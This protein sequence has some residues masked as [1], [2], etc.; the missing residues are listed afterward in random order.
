MLLK[1]QPMLTECCHCRREMNKIRHATFLRAMNIS[2][3]II[4]GRI[5]LFAILLTYIFQGNILNA[6]VVFV[7]MTYI[8]QVRF[9]MTWLFPN[10]VALFSEL[11]VSCRRIQ[12]FLMLDE[13]N[14]LTTADDDDNDYDDK[15]GGKIQRYHRLKELSPNQ[16]A[17]VEMKNVSVR[18]TMVN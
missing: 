9:S 5:V 4:S 11:T 7:V 18:W 13:I 17:G 14:Q 8:Y 12:T 6:D 2:I 1:Q 15:K 16:E 10:V 3:S